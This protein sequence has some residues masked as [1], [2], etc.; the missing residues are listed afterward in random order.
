MAVEEYASSSPKGSTIRPR[1]PSR[2]R[3]P[4]DP[5]PRENASP[6]SGGGASAPTGQWRDAEQFATLRSVHTGSWLGL[7]YQGQGLGKEMRRAILH[8]AFA[9]LG[10]QEAHSGAFFDNA[11]SLATSRSVGYE[12][13]G[14][15]LGPRRDGVARMLNVRMDRATWEERRRD[16]IEIVGL[17]GCLD[18]VHRRTCAR[19]RRRVS[20]GTRPAQRRRRPVRP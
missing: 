16:D 5:R 1:C 7:N 11:P 13:N 4:T 19:R 2:C 9:G 17:E 14:E 3:G 10:A 8:L 15:T 12:P 18:I 6:P 20:A